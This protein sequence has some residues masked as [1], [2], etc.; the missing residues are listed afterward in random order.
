MA[1]A[2]SL[3]AQ[4]TSS[5][6]TKAL[7]EQGHAAAQYSMGAMYE[8]GD[9]VPQDTNKAVEWYQRAAAQDNVMA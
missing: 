4:A 3:S 6:N 8:L 1:F 5:T 2:L 7:A 9:G